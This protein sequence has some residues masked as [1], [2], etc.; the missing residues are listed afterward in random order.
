MDTRCV[1]A[2]TAALALIAACRGRG[3]AIER[4]AATE[5]TYLIV[6]NANWAD[7]TIF[8]ARG[9]T[10]SRIGFVSALSTRTLPVPRSAMPDGTVRLL[11]DPLGS[12]KV[13]LTQSIAVS[14]GQHVELTVMPALT[15]TTFAVRS[16]PR[17]G[18]ERVPK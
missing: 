6:T 14:P 18:P 15:M 4:V 5:Q 10:R 9:A 3:L 8:I 16:T 17:R 12:N 1:V 13:H 11:L 2:G 7:V